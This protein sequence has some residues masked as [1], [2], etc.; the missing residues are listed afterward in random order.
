MPYTGELRAFGL[1]KETTIGTFV[2]PPTVVL[3]YIPPLSFSPAIPLLESKGV[4]QVADMVVKATQGKAEVKGMKL[5][6]EAE[7]DNIGQILQACFGADT[8]TGSTAYTHTFARTAVSQ[9]PT[10]TAY[11]DQGAT[12]T[13]IGGCM[14][15][16]F[17][18]DVKSG[19]LITV[20]T[21]WT[22][23]AY[24]STT[25][26]TLPAFSTLQPF[27]FNTAAISVGGTAILDYDNFKLSIDNMVKADHVVIASIYPGKIYSEGM[28][29]QLSMDMYVESGNIAQ[30]TTNYLTGVAQA[31]V[32]TLT[33]PAFAYSGIHFSLTSTIP[34]LKY[35]TAP[36]ANP[37]AVL[38]IPFAGTALYDL[39]NTNQT[40]NAVLVN[41][42]STAY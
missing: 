12:Y 7:P 38:K 31:V 29:V 3:P 21:E 27:A 5:K 36:F 19:E 25:E 16:K 20:D 41:D 26:Q 37:Q 30:W 6:I 17:D 4:R 42:V 9:L 11:L 35:Q 33:H 2:L 22:G 18:L 23:T 10:Y 13:V 1:A 40:L 28:K 24:E 34:V 39:G 15:G 14:L 32:I 8:K